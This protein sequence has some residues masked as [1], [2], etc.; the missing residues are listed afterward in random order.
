[1]I[2]NAS[3]SHF[4][5]VKEYSW[6]NAKYE[7]KTTSSGDAK[8]KNPRQNDCCGEHCVRNSHRGNHDSVT[9]LTPSVPDIVN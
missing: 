7:N 6:R 8:M 2:N 5:L 3:A 9:L 1:M 4:L